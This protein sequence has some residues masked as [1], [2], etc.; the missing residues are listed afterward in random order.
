MKL[1]IQYLKVKPYEEA[2]KKV[3]RLYKRHGINSA[4]RMMKKEA[5]E[6]IYSLHH[7]GIGILN[8]NSAGGGLKVYTEDAD[9][10]PSMTT[11]SKE[12]VSSRLKCKPLLYKRLIW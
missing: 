10:N 1:E 8:D 4:N 9:G 7:P 6:K 2:W 3:A 11:Y 5:F 12:M